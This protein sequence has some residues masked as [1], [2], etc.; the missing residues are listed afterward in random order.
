MSTTN[1]LEQVILGSGDLYVLAFDGSVPANATIEVDDNLIGRIQGGAEIS[2]KP[3]IKTVED[4]SGK[5]VRRFITKEEVTLKSG[6]LTWCVATLAKLAAAG[7]YT[8]ETVSSKKIRKLKIGGKAGRA[9]AEY[10]IRFVH[11]KADGNKLRC[12]IAGNAASGFSLAFEPEKETVVDAEF[13]AIA[14]DA[15]GTQV[16]LEEEFEAEEEE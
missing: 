1:E 6:V 8:E 2:Y 10:L 7:N 4:D 3:S 13:S 14:C 11:V 16:I 12:T 15:D 5:I 9:L